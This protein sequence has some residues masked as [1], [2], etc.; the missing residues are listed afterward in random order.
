MDS[1][2]LGR[3]H[4]MAALR[5]IV[6]SLDDLNARVSEMENHETVRYRY[7]VEAIEHLQDRQEELN[8]LQHQNPQA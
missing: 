1:V 4:V 5:G 2:T 7:L 8:S 6:K 3:T